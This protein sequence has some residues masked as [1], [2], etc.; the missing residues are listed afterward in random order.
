MPTLPSS[1]FII[2]N[3]VTSSISE[4]SSEASSASDVTCTPDRELLENEENEKVCYHRIKGE[5]AE[6]ILYGNYN[7]NYNNDNDNDNDDNWNI[8]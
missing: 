5:H 7:Y 1:V 2:W 4:A 6:L 3:K 8:E